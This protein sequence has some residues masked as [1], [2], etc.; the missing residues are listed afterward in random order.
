MQRRAAPA[1]ARACC[2]AASPAARSRSA[3]RSSC[4][5]AARRRSVAE[6]HVAG[7]RVD[8]VGAGRSAGVVLDRQLDVSRGD[9]L[10]A[11]G[12][13]APT[14]RFRATL[15]WLDTEPAVDR[16]QVLAAPRQPLAAGP[17]RRD[18]EPARHRHARRAR[19][20]RARRQRD[21]RGRSS[22]RSSRC[23]SRASRR[24]RRRRAARRRPGDEPHQRRAARARLL[25]PEPTSSRARRGRVPTAESSRAQDEPRPR[26]GPSLH[27]VDLVEHAAVGEVRLLRLGPAAEHLVDREQRDLRELR[28]VLRGDLVVDRPVEVLRRDLLAVGRIE[29]LEVGLGDLPA[30]R[31]CR[32]PCRPPPPAARRGCWSADRRSRTCRRRTP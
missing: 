31:A 9:W 17:H 26:R 8:R 25:R 4:S 29:V 20:A 21:R 18:R 28:R 14:A 23:R 24:P 19:S 32:R 16:P 12:S 13:V 22:R 5:R 11:P 1:T 30:C 27:A 2:G 10:A 6:L 15:A 7:G 3:R